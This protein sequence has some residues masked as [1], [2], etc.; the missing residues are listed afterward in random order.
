[1]VSKMRADLR[2]EQIG[3]E[4]RQPR[5]CDGLGNLIVNVVFQRQGQILYY[6]RA[7]RPARKSSRSGGE[8]PEIRMSE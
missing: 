8:K 6:T 1:M 4:H 7:G 3:A 2:G 5:V